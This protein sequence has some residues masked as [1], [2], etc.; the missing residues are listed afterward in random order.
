MTIDLGDAV[1]VL[2]LFAL[3]VPCVGEPD[4]LDAIVEYVRAAARKQ[5]A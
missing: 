1:A 3:I 4:L 2:C 5:A